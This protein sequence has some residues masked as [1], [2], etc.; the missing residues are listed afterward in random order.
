MAVRLNWAG[1]ANRAMRFL[2]CAPTSHKEL[3]SNTRAEG[4]CVRS[5]GSYGTHKYSSQDL[6]GLESLTVTLE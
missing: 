2:W 4:C 6:I 1:T 5:G 3:G